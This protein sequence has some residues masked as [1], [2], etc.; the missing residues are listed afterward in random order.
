MTQHLY[1]ISILVPDY[2]K[3][4]AH[5]CNDLGFD[6]A[7]DTDMGGG[8]RFVRITPPIP[9][10]KEQG[11]QCSLLLAK[12]K[13]GAQADAIGH[14]FGGRV[15]LFLHT[16]DFARDYAAY[17]AAGIRFCEASPRHEIY[18]TVIV[19]EDAFGLKWDL[20]QPA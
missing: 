12:A 17:Q 11:G 14:Q 20:V 5:Y 13:P 18:G 8:K 1:A 3:A 4:I 10:G 16:D 19:F 9:Q 7:E 2:D 15:G 6:L